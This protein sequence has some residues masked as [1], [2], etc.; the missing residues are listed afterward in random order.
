M[1]GGSQRTGVSGKF[2]LREAQRGDSLRQRIW[3]IPECLHNPSDPNRIDFKFGSQ[4]ASDCYQDNMGEELA[5]S[6]KL[7]LAPKVPQNLW[8][9]G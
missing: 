1:F 4:I 3:R 5:A 9:S 7:G 2:S 6:E 8:G